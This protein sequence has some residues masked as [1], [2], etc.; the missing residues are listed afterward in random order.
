M[1]QSEIKSK[2]NPRMK[3]IVLQVLETQITGKNENGEPVQGAPDVLECAKTTFE[4]LSKSYGAD[5]AKSMMADAVTDVIWPMMS[6]HKP[7]NAEKY[8]TSLEKL[9]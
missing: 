8:K 1:A 2:Y 9:K 5:K 3:E 7:F 6:E 4:R